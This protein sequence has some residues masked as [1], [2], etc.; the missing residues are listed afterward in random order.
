MRGNSGARIIETV[1]KWH[2]DAMIEGA[3]CQHL[4]EKVCPRVYT[5]A[6]GYYTMEKLGEI[7]PRPTLL[8]EIERAL[9]E[10]V[11]A[12]PTQN[13]DVS[14]QMDFLEFHRSMGID[15]P[16]WA[17]P[18]E[19]CLIHGDPTVSNAMTR[20]ED[21]RLILIDPR[22]PNGHIPSWKT[23]DMGKIL[24]SYFNWEVVAYG[25]KP[26]DY[27]LPKFMQDEHML[28]EAMFWCFYHVS[29]IEQHERARN[30][31]R[32]NILDWCEEVKEITW[33]KFGS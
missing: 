21:N 31:N 7:P 2:S 30:W 33:Q 11:W 25:S 6:S 16:S 20:E 9:E 23:V 1:T 18:T 22:A 29:R 4:G 5:T 26:V 28:R 10:Y 19:F 8:R 32:T 15:T 24:Q 27:I 3:F 12:R 17:I 14:G 13:Y